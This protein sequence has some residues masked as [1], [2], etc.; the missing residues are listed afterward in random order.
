TVNYTAADPD[1]DFTIQGNGTVTVNQQ[2]CATITCLGESVVYNNSQE[3]YVSMQFSINGGTN[4]FGFNNDA[5]VNG[6]ESVQV[7]TP[8]GSNIVLKAK[9]VNQ[10]QNWS[11]TLLSNSGSQYVYVLQNG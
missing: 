11:N 6:G 8:A 2:A 9:C 4:W 1:I 7:A 3:A 10:Y 5:Y